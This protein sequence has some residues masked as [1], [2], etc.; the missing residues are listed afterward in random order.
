MAASEGLPKSIFA[1]DTFILPELN[2]ITSRYWQIFLNR[3][4]GKDFI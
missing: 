2:I 1:L 3:N 4:M